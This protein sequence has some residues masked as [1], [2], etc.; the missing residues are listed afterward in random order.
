MHVFRSWALGGNSTQPGFKPS[1]FTYCEVTAIP[2]QEPLIQLKGARVFLQI[3]DDLWPTFRQWSDSAHLEACRWAVTDLW[4]CSWFA[5]DI[6]PSY[7]LKL[8]L[9]HSLH[10]NFNPPPPCWQ[11]LCG[12]CALFVTWCGA[13]WPN[14]TGLCFSSFCKDRPWC[15]ILLDRIDFLLATFPNKPYLFGVFCTVMNFTR[16]HASWDL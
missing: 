6:S 1:T 14:T 15:H 2:L 8:Y 16:F 7:E 3:R 11:V 4:R 10:Q 5:R 9:W 12:V 13:L